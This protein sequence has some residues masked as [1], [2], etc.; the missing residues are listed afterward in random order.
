MSVVSFTIYQQY[1]NLQ[2]S[3]W[4]FGKITN[5]SAWPSRTMTNK[6]YQNK[7]NCHRTL[8]CIFTSELFKIKYHRQLTHLNRLN[9]LTIAQCS[10]S[11]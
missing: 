5:Y 11:M 6:Q 2:V 9:L 3:Q 1:G 4:N 7:Q 10:I 8:L